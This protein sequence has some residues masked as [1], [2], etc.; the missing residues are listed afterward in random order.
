MRDISEWFSQEEEREY[1]MASAVQHG[2]S[3]LLATGHPPDLERVT[4]E[5][6]ARL[7]DWEYSDAWSICAAGVVPAECAR[8]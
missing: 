6:G 1:E 5:C 2:P 7:C 3:A 4:Q 8:K